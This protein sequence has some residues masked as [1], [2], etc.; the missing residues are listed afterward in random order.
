MGQFPGVHVFLHDIL[1]AVRGSQK[2]HWREVK[3]VHHVLNDNN[4]A[5]K[6]SKCTFFVQETELLWFRLSKKGTVPVERKIT[7]IVNKKKLETITLLN[8]VHKPIC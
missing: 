5:V 2:R 4:A 8:P 1:I 6:W 3:N 7:S